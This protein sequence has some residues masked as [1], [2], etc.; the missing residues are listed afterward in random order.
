M[1]RE[2]AQ[3]KTN[4][5]AQSIAQCLGWVRPCVQP[6]VPSKGRVGGRGGGQKEEEEEEE[7]EEE[8]QEEE[9][10]PSMSVLI[11]F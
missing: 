9:K 11:S 7:Q 10:N 6:P 4:P 3:V 5:G 2:F 8:E 1:F